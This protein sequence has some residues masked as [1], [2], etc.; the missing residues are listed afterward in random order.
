MK[1]GLN[2]NILSC[3]ALFLAACTDYVDEYKG[4]YE[5][6][7]GNEET[8][9]KNLNK[10]DW[11]WLA[12]CDEGDW[13]WCAVKDGEY[14]SETTT[15][16]TWK[17]TTEGSASLIFAG[18]DDRAYNFTTDLLPEDL[19]PFIRLNGGI[20][21]R[22]E[23]AEGKFEAG[24][25][26]KVGNA[27]IAENNHAVFAYGNEYSGAKLCLR[28]V[29]GS[30]NVKSEWCWALDQK[31]SVSV[32]TFNYKDLKYVKGTKD[33]SQFI[34]DAN[35]F[36]VILTAGGDVKSGLTVVAFGFD[37]DAF[38]KES[39]ELDDS[40][41]S[42]NEKS[43]SSSAKSSS[44]NKESST[45][46]TSSSTVKNSSSAT[47][48]SSSS[49]PTSSAVSSSSE[50]S[51]N[52]HTSFMWD[53]AD[54]TNG[55]VR[56]YLGPDGNAGGVWTFLTDTLN[57][58]NTI[59]IKPEDIFGTCN[60]LCGMAVFGN[61]A[62]TPWAQAYFD[63]DVRFFNKTYDVSTWD[64]LCIAYTSDRKVTLKLNPID[65]TPYNN[66]VPVFDLPKT[67][68]DT[69]YTVRNIKWKE[70]KQGGWGNGERIT[71]EEIVRELKSIA[72]QFMGTAG[73]SQFFNIYRI[74][75]YNDCG[76]TVPTAKREINADYFNNLLKS[77]SSSAGSSSSV[78]IDSEGCNAT[79]LWCKNTSYRVNT[80]V[81]A[82]S[83]N[84]GYWWTANDNGNGGNSMFEWPVP[85]GNGFSGDA[86]D[87]VIDY[88]KG[89]CGTYALNK[90]TS[91]DSPW[92]MIG[93]SIAGMSATSSDNV[94]A[95]VSAWDGVCVTYTSSDSLKMELHFESDIEDTL[96]HDL[97]FVKFPNSTTVTDTC[98]VWSDFAQGGWGIYD[99]G[100]PISSEEAVKYVKDIAFMI[101][102][103]DGSTGD[104]NIIRLQKIN[105]SGVAKLSTWSYQNPNIT[106]GL[107][108]DDRD[109]QLYKTIEINGQ[110]WMAEN[111]NYDYQDGTSS[112]CHGNHSSNCS[113][114]GRLYTWDAAYKVC[115]EG[116]YLPSKS[117]YLSWLGSNYPAS[118]LKTTSGWGAY[119]GT[120]SVGFSAL[121]AGYNYISN[122]Q[123][124]GGLG[125]YAF[126]WTS[127]DD[128][129]NSNKA[130]RVE[131]NYDNP[132]VNN[133]VWSKTDGLSVR[134]VQGW[135]FNDSRDDKKYKTVKIGNQIWMAENLNY[136]YNESGADRASS[137]TCFENNPDYCDIYGRLYGR[138]AAMNVCPN[139]WNLPLKSDL[140]ALVAATNV[141]T[142]AAGAKLKT[143]DGWEP[144]SAAGTDDLG[145]SARPGGIWHRDQ[146]TFVWLKSDAHFWASYSL[147]DTVAEYGM[148]LNT[149]TGVLL[150]EYVGDFMFSVRCVRDD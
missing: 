26:V 70:F 57:N 50:E 3:V 117:D 113:L 84:A 61:Q 75:S 7:Y 88:C 106:Y 51:S 147:E 100:I 92:V 102:G 135:K 25:Q 137:S 33:L 91:K 62:E 65:D 149:R 53:G 49:A 14:M 10:L 74:G 122:A 128:A 80:G 143:V 56:T 21:F 46:T 112:W 99:D 13:I 111:L 98:V 77:S 42:T 31:S 69:P 131:L 123:N 118:R 29:E 22:L 120:D 39:D 19:T 79:D 114:Y 54:S 72:V 141:D 108:R 144:S 34:E 58:G 38:G 23:K 6:A 55:V 40:S 87:P 133:N 47:D 83:D 1:F 132:Y 2:V 24:L 12:S 68:V 16:A 140:D 73:S 37:G 52:S 146:K 101:Y 96:R 44:S 5:E 30:D 76:T 32:K 129:G 125:D 81:H 63:L 145:F 9:L 134:C 148:C 142:S 86:F 85:R 138:T 45:A 17:Q 35:T 28:S 136:A 139:G 71:G 93:F 67:P 36:A 107:M 8:F 48:N 103:Q 105:T 121:S 97:P 90:G 64:G 109:G 89:I 43:S 66:D 41:S 11:E 18:K 150:G 15:G 60:G 82:D 130:Y 4:D 104:F 20:S 116:W 115:P 59:I 95:D 127:T 78:G 27:I 124:F 119:N 94:P 110:T 126:F